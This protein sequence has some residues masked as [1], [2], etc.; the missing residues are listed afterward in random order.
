MSPNT[1]ELDF[2]RRVLAHAS[3]ML[4]YWDAGL[5]CRFA[6]EGCRHWL[7]RGTD[8]VVGRRMRDLLGA[9]LFAIDEPHVMAALAG[10]AQVFERAAPGPD[11][12]VRHSLVR[13][14]PDRVDHVV[15]GFIAEVTDVSL[16]KKLELE[17]IEQAAIKQCALAAVK[18]RDAALNAA[19]RLGKIGSWE[20]EVAADITT[21]SPELYRL[22]GRDVRRLSPPFSEH[23]A[24]Y[25]A[26]SWQ[27]LRDAVNAA[28]THAVPYHLQLEY[29][30]PGLPD[31]W[32]D[33]RGEVVRDEKGSIV[34]LR[35]TA[36]DIT[37]S[38]SMLEKVREQA[39]RLALALGAADMGMWHWDVLHDTFHCEDRRA[40]DFL[41]LADHVGPVGAGKFCADL[42]HPDDAGALLGAMA[43]CTH[44]GASF[45]FK[46][47]VRRHGADG[48][49]WIECFG[50]MR[51][52]QDTGAMMTAVVA[53]VTDAVATGQAL[54]RAVSAMTEADGRKTAFLSILGHELRNGLA[55]VKAGV[56]L[57]GL[58][59]EPATLHKITA[60]MLRQVLHLER[61]VDDIQDLRRMQHGEIS[62]QRSRIALATVL[63]GAA[64]MVRD[65]MA[66]RHHDFRVHFPDEPLFVDGDLVRLTQVLVNLL[67]NAA[68][69]TPPHGVITLALHAGAAGTARIVVT[70]NG[71]GI[72]SEQVE[73]IFGMY[74]RVPAA[75]GGDGEEGLGIGLYL[76]RK[77]VE[78]HG[79]TLAAASEGVGRGSVMEVCLPVVGDR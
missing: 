32:L 17:L 1:N 65:T 36:Q 45:H 3:S 10:R 19:Q 31:G 59:Q 12:G 14:H 40:R 76:A 20:W 60:A 4:S 47:R 73:V 21:W 6:N 35:G 42:I 28:L 53:D 62:L 25:S 49:R 23:A 5:V 78:L 44:G 64:D 77:L 9:A 13:Y 56:Q 39:Q 55:P 11:G 38:Y 68:K 71:I 8:S 67:C 33:V 34:A 48:W 50:Q 52:L 61:L 54:E 27:R 75:D 46:G 66:R 2:S 18:K 58:H 22:F 63:E 70:D 79:G 57:L 30:R 15:V 51:A 29:V 69:F 26:A 72:A 7:G 24:L 41:G 43:I 37:E 16:L 74:V